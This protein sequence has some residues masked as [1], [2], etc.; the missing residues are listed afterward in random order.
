MIVKIDKAIKLLPEKDKNDFDYYVRNE[1]S[2]NQGN[3]FITK[4]DKIMDLFF[5]DVFDWLE[6][7]ELVF[8]FKMKEYRKIRMYTFLAERYLPYWFKKYTKSLEW[9]VIYCDINKDKK[10]S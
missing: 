9:P 3:M 1:V 5:K 10:N 4:S 2:F 6:K 8:G 7:C